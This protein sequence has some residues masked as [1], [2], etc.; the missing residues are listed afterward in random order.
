MVP[1]VCLIQ[2]F[3]KIVQSFGSKLEHFKS[4]KKLHEQEISVGIFFKQKVHFYFGDFFGVELIEQKLLKLKNWI[5]NQR[6]SM[7][8]IGTC[9]AN[10]YDAL[11]SFTR[12][13]SQYGACKPG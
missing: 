12:G 7:S 2:T 9:I 10:A 11:A 1:T 3:I 8:T 5:P 4:G 13:I 6:F